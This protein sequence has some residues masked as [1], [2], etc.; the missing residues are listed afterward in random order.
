MPQLSY[1]ILKCFTHNYTTTLNV[2][3]IVKM[4]SRRHQITELR[5][6]ITYEI[7]DTVTISNQQTEV[8]TI[9][10]RQT[11]IYKTG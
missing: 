10:Y 3:N 7:Q 11:I 2:I 1:L 6:I 5:K 8:G 9:E 4:L